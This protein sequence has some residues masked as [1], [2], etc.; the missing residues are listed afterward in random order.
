MKGTK[1]S[2]IASGHKSQI[3]APGPMAL[4]KI[5]LAASLKIEKKSGRKPKNSIGAKKQ[6][7]CAQK[8]N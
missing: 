1:G 2:K 6:V 7:L 8:P 3:P 4:L 5:G